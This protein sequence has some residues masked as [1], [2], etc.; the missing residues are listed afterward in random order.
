MHGLQVVCFSRRRHLEHHDQAGHRRHVAGERGRTT[1]RSPPALE[2]ELDGVFAPRPCR[3]GRAVSRG[4][5][6]STS[7][8]F[9]SRRGPEE[10]RAPWAHAR[11]PRGAQACH[12][13]SAMLP[14]VQLQLVLLRLPL[15][16]GAVVLHSAGA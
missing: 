12:R 8:V 11:G 3:E 9:C 7:G 5:P 6:S 13:R 15:P 14:R 16:Y 2:A 4:V 1:R 10:R